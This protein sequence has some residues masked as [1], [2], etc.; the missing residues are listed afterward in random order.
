M[1]QGKISLTRYFPQINIFIIITTTVVLIFI[2][3]NLMVK[4]TF[5]QIMKKKKTEMWKIHE[6]EIFQHL[7]EFTIQIWEDN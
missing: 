1:V 2:L 5:C 3:K 4:Y 6:N 7:L